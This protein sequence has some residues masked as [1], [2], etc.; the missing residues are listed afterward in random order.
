MQLKAFYL[1]LFFVILLI[2]SLSA[3]SDG[4]MEKKLQ[5]LFENGRY[6][7]CYQKAVRF[8]KNK[9]ESP[10]PE[11]YISKINIQKYAA[12]RSADSDE[13]RLFT[14]FTGWGESL[15]AKY[16]NWSKFESD[17]LLARDYLVYDTLQLYGGYKKE[18]N[19]FLSN[20]QDTLS[21]I[22]YYFPSFKALKTEEGVGFLSRSDSLRWEIVRYAESFMG[23]KYSYSGDKPETG[24]D[25]SG[26]TQYVY[27]HV[28]VELPHNA[29][30]QS[31]SEGR[32][33]TLAEAKA[34]DLIFF[35]SSS[36]G[37]EYIRHT[38]IICS[39]DND[40]IKV[41]HCATGGVQI[42]DKLTD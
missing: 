18:L 7:K 6:E 10:V 25:C 40:E 26:F 37:M 12:Q 34:G 22:S 42:D 28:G 27:H 13:F 29:R 21:V 4:R 8:H 11:C 23:V 33:I 14:R 3:Q 39:I 35:G 30:Q 36:K 2:H 31:E 20:F 41:I 16:G 32:I 9:P 17:S 24:F 1:V 38:G 19:F 15:P 5:H